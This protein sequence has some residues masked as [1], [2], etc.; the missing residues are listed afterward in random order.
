MAVNVDDETLVRDFRPV[1]ETNVDEGEEKPCERCRKPLRLN[2]R[3]FAWAR[4]AANY[5]T[6]RPLGV[7]VCANC[8]AALSERV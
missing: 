4:K 8:N 1:G 3:V 7:E 5:N 2:D 6:P